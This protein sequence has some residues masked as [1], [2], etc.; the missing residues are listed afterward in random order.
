MPLRDLK[1]HVQ[2]LKDKKVGSSGWR[3]SGIAC[4]GQFYPVGK[5]K[6]GTIIRFL[7]YFQRVL[8]SYLL[9]RFLLSL[10]RVLLFQ[11]VLLSFVWID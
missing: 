7:L 1:M 5:R 2:A 4:S 3:N 9:I 11:R 8:L 10:K 6:G